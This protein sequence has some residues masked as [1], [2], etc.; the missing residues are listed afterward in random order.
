MERHADYTDENTV[1]VKAYELWLQRGCPQG[2]PEDDWY[3][4]E[5]LLHTEP[6][7]PSVAARQRKR[8]SAL[9]RTTHR[10]LPGFPV[11]ASRR[12]VP[13][14]Y[15]PGDAPRQFEGLPDYLINVV[16]QSDTRLAF[17]F[18]AGYY[19]NPSAPTSIHLC[20]NGCDVAQA[21]ESGAQVSV[22]LGCT[23]TVQVR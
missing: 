20:P 3:Q 14:R 22:V 21:A 6:R 1:R 18:I 11:T 4:A 17:Q 12:A 7:A 10:P 5:R 19:D 16:P 2:S 13:P 8:S 15:V 23:E 9:R